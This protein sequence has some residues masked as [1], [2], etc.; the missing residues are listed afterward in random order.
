MGARVPRSTIWG[1]VYDALG[2]KQEALT[3]YKQALAISQEVGDRG[4][5]GT[6][7]N[8]LGSVYDALGQKQEALTY[9]KQALAISQEVG[10]RGGEGTTL[11]NLG[12][13]SMMP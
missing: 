7:L 4:G 9:Y 6:T 11:N 3:Y 2:Q 1:C 13:V 5:E 10:D 8:N 12:Y